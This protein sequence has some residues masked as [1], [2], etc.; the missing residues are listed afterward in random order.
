MNI[1]DTLKIYNLS[2]EKVS[3]R[4]FTQEELS[5]IKEAV[6]ETSTYGLTVRFNLKSGGCTFIPLHRDSIC[7][8][9]EIIDLSQATIVTLKRG[10]EEI[11]RIKV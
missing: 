6:V 7:G 10:N 2:W 8:C 5:C 1:F 11:D 4:H 3:E 9:G